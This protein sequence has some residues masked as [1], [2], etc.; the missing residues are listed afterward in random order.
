MRNRIT[1]TLL[2][3]ALALVPALAAADQVFDFDGVTV[4]PAAPGEQLVAS[5]VVKDVLPPLTTPIPLDFAAHEYT[6]VVTA[7]LDSATAYTQYFSSGTVA[8]YEDDATPADPADPST[9]TDGTVLLSGELD[10]LVRNLF[11]TGL[12][13]GSG[14]LDWTGGERLG[15]FPEADRYGWTLLF[16]LDA[17]VDRAVGFDETWEGTLAPATEIVAAEE[18]TWSELK[19]LY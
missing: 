18:L 8:L 4:T 17:G 11:P 15:T 10:H 9:Y 12:G 16:T 1:T 3:A 7:V 14:S 2:L 6:L 19:A 13:S 5:C